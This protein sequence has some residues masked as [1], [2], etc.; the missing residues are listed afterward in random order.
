M[1]G[2]FNHN[3]KNLLIGIAIGLV[4]G[5]F[6]GAGS[7]NLY[8]SAK[9]NLPTVHV[10]VETSLENETEDVLNIVSETTEANGILEVEGL[11]D[12]SAVEF[13][14]S[15][16]YYKVTNCTDINI[17]TITLNISFYDKN[18]DIVNGSFPQMPNVVQPG[19]SIVFEGMVKVGEGAYSATA[20]GYSF[21]DENGNYVQGKFTKIPEPTVL[22]TE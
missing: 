12:Q 2:F 3:K 17:N 10:N 7:M 13:G 6:V 21:Y 15:C 5:I 4:V 9:R 22:K 8:I 11:P 20:D 19:Q 14:Y 1:A 16:V 18:G